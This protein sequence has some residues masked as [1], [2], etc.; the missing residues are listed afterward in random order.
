[1]ELFRRQVVVLVTLFMAKEPVSGIVLSQKSGLSLNTLKKEIDELN[2][3]CADQGFEILSKTGSGYEISISD[4]PKYF[5]FR[6]QII[7]RYHRNL[8]FRDSQTDRVHYIIRRMLS[9]DHMFVEEIADE[10]FCSV[11][12]INRDM[13]DVK[14]RLEQRKVKLVN[15]TNR[16]MKLEGREWNIRM[17]FLNEYHIYRDFETAYHFQE[18]S[19]EKQFL[20]GSPARENIDKAVVR[21]LDRHRYPISYNVIMDLCNLFV[22]TITRQKHQRSLQK[23][24]ELFTAGD[25]SPE[26]GIIGEILE[27]IARAQ[28]VSL[29]ACEKHSLAAFLKASRILT[30]DTLGQEEGGEEAFRLADGFLDHMKQTVSMPGIDTGSLRGDVACGLLMLARK[31]RLNIHTAHSDIASFA[32]EGLMCLDFCALLYFWLLENTDIACTGWDA[33]NFYYIFTCFARERERLYRKRI[34]IVSRYGIYAARGMAVQ[35]QRLNGGFAV[36]YIPCGYLDARHLDM[37]TVDCIAT[38]IEEMQKEYPDK[39]FASVHYFRHAW[40]AAEFVRRTIL[41]RELFR[42]EIFRREDLFYTDRVRTMKDVEQMIMT[43]VLEAGD[44]RE[45]YLAGLAKKMDVFPPNRQNQ[46]M[47]LNTLG[48]VLGRDFFKIAVMKKPVRIG[49][50]LVS[51]IVMFNVRDNDLERLAYLNGRIAALLHV[52]GITLTMAP[53]EDYETLVRLM[54]ES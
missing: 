33:M 41:P 19:F 51:M 49:N 26:Y 1:M 28:Q 10:C 24:E 7:S 32:R 8:F 21:V 29:T 45:R 47:V 14:R 3:S 17:A 50:S 35:F 31:C 15:H 6:R 43:R 30:A 40:Q 39:R 44:D 38:D 37:S 18:D 46:V 34:L 16:G 42:A 11:S 5:A 12:T 22:L 9:H 25:D 20:D 36:E 2:Y 54:Y 4:R 53:E 13:K 27:D 23:D 48:D 52:D